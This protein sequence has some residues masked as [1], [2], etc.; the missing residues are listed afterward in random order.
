MQRGL[1][2]GTMV[3]YGVG[4]TDP[5]L[6]PFDPHG[7]QAKQVEEFLRKPTPVLQVTVLRE[8]AEA[9]MRWYQ[10]VTLLRNAADRLKHSRPCKLWQALEASEWARANGFPYVNDHELASVWLYGKVKRA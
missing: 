9:V 10:D 1:M 7:E 3:M 2:P 4:V 8:R 5:L 6:P